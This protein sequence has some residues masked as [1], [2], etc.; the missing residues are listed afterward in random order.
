MLIFAHYGWTTPL[1]VVALILGPALVLLCLYT[2][3]RRRTPAADQPVSETSP[4]PEAIEE[5]P[6]AG[7]PSWDDTFLDICGVIAK[8]SKDERTQLGSVLVGPCKEIRSVGYN[9]FPRG[10]ND[11]VPERQS[12]EGGY[13]YLWFSHAERNALDNALRMGTPTLGCT[14]YVPAHPCADCARGLIQA[15]IKEVV[16]SSCT[17]PVRF[18]DN[19]KAAATMF[20][21]AG[22]L[23]RLAN[24]TDQLE[25]EFGEG[26]GA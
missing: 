24:S 13:K 23:V 9:C 14:C 2:R 26:W 15:G 25:L 22:V 1:I 16:V 18:R 7:R 20:Q 5:S 19:C 17:V 3:S 4:P 12:R 8:R 6:P 10:I 11:D 21:E